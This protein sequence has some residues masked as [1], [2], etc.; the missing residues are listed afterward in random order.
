ME[1]DKE[2]KKRRFKTF[3]MEIYL[4]IKMFFELMFRIKIS[5]CIIPAA[6]ITTILT[7][8]SPQQRVSRIVEKY[9][10]SIKDTTIIQADTIKTVYSKDVFNHDTIFTVIQDNAKTK[11]QV[12]HDSVFITT[13]IPEKTIITEKIVTEKKKHI[14][15]IIIAALLL[16]GALCLTVYN[17][18]NI[19]K[20]G[21]QS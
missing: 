2:D 20:Y 19:H 17:Y 10:L 12:Q 5:R 14:G 4:K 13:F 21:K 11:I 15:S 18:I 1:N 8:C 7:G 6:V 16:A 3:V 9:N